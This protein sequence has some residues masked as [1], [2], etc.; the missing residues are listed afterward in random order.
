MQPNLVGAV[1]KMIFAPIIMQLPEGGFRDKAAMPK[2][3]PIGLFRF[4]LNGR[5]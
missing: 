2:A 4:C 5:R 1:A 3:R